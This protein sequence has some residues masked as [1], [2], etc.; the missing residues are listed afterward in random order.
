MS[1]FIPYGHQCVQEDDI[2][3]VV[4]VLQSDWLTQG[5]MVERFE[6][7]FA[8]S[9]GTNYAVAFSS[10]TAAVHAAYFAA[11]VGEGDEIITSPNTFCATANAALYLNAKPVFVDIDLDTYNVN[12]KCVEA[13]ISSKTKAIVPVHFAGRPCDMQSLKQLA[14]EK[15]CVLIAD[16]CHALGASYQN[17]SIAAWAD[18]SCFSFHPVKH[19]ATGEG[20]MVVTNNADYAQTLKE[21]RTHGI[22]KDPESLKIASPGDWYYEMQSL[23][24]NYRMSDIHAALGVSQ[25]SKLDGFIEQRRRIAGL[26]R[27]ILKDMSELVVPENVDGHAYHLCVVRVLNGKRDALFSRL[28]ESG[29]GVQVHYVPVYHMP[30]YQDRGFGEYRQTCVQTEQYY[31]ECISLPVYVGLTDAQIEQ[32]C[33]IVKGTLV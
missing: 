31:Q 6:K 15:S 24:Y 10:G 23:G 29:V 2:S 9:A 28:R 22:I 7:K 8:E 4:D 19:I 13:A 17:K 16:A 25:L 26:Y 27:D 21:F 12:V 18:M 20:G 33:Q 11:G 30:Y 14:E 32:V 5:P 1:D 3:A